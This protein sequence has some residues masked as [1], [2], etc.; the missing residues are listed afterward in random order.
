MLKIRI[1]TE[2]QQF[3]SM[4]PFFKGCGR[5]QIATFDHRFSDEIHGYSPC[6]SLLLITGF[7][8]NPKL[9]GAKSMD[10]IALLTIPIGLLIK[11][12]LAI[13]VIG[14]GYEAYKI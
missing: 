4:Q 13:G 10:A 3:A 8:T 5:P 11:A 9:S 6:V 2:I 14:N 7:T 12:V 1:A